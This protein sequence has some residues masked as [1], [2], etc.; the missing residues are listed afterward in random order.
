MPDQIVGYYDARRKKLLKDFDR[1]CELIKSSLID[2]YGEDSAGT[3]RSD[4]RM[5][6]EK[7]IPEIPFIKGPR[8]GMLTVFFLFPPRSL[9]PTKR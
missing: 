9:Q 7:L 4:A 5:E 3:L 2:R 6:Y 1:T 8:A